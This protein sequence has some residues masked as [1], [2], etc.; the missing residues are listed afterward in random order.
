M[1]CEREPG[2]M[3]GVISALRL[4]GAGLFLALYASIRYLNPM[5]AAT[6]IQWSECR[7]EVIWKN[8]GRSRNKSCS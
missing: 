2:A 7:N 6:G 8:L 1:P 3:Q 4:V 5:P